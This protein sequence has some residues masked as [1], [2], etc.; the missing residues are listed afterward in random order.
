MVGARGA[1]TC[2]QTAYLCTTRPTTPRNLGSSRSWRASPSMF[3]LYTTIVRRRGCGFP[4]L[5]GEHS[6]H[7]VQRFEQYHE[8]G[9]QFLLQAH[10][11]AW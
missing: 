2:A 4:E 1:A 5:F 10:L 9:P 3:R 6:E 8:A 11:S 7:W